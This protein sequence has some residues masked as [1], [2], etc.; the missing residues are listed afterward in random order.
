MKLKRTGLLSVQARRILFI[1]GILTSLI[2]VFIVSFH[3]YLPEHPPHYLLLA[4]DKLK[5]LF[6]SVPLKDKEIVKS[7]SL[8]L[9]HTKYDSSQAAAHRHSAS[10]RIVVSN[11]NKQFAGFLSLSA[12]LSPP[13]A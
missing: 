4:E 6:K 12:N 3:D 10:N 1:T 2:F 9:I 8:F 7:H 5:Q 11:S 13:A